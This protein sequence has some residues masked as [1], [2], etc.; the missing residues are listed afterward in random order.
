[1]RQREDQSGRPGFVFGL[2]LALTMGVGPLALYGLSATAPMVIEDLGLSRAQFGSLGTVAFLVAAVSS[3]LLGQYVDR[4]AARSV[5]IVLY[6]GA[7][8]AFLT[9]AAANSFPLLL[10]AVAISGCAQ[11]LS[12][13]V[14]NRLI[15]T[16]I[17][18]GGRGLLMGVK[19][20]GVQMSQL[21]AGLALPTVALLLGWRVA[22][23]VCVVAAAAGLWLAFRFPSRDAEQAAGEGGRRP[24]SGL[25]TSVWWLMAYALLTGAGLHASNMYLPLFSY[26]ELE[27]SATVAGFTAAVVGGVGLV[28]RIGFGHAAD[29]MQ[30]PHWA[31]S[32]L[33][34]VAALGAMSLLASSL[35]GQPSLM[36]LGAVVFGASGI[37]TNVVVMLAL[38]RVTPLQV[39]GTA[40]GLV[41]I[42][43]YSGFAIGPISF[44]L[45]VDAAGSY[46]LGWLSVVITYVA[47]AV[48]G[49][50]WHS[51]HVVTETHADVKSTLVRPEGDRDGG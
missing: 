28:A 23:G 37:A 50:L 14:T 2:T 48:L 20:A 44:G 16:W 5:M 31:L 43:L 40:S 38:I 29:R 33:A 1:V 12:N 21:V 39:V 42:G 6:I 8:L 26:E 25:P 11:S 3:A 15:S 41:A 49:F 17:P 32:A 9:A 19:Q 47:A 27:L 4:H 36:W 18:P 46:E 7:A 35:T 22:L 24:A 30:R 51:R 45:I 34:A 13:P 10:V